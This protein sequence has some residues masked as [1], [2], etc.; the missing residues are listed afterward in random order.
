MGRL[1]A[2]SCQVPFVHQQLMASSRPLRELSR[3]AKNPP[4]KV[5][6]LVGRYEYV[7]RTTLSPSSVPCFSLFLA[8]RMSVALSHAVQL[9][10]AS[11]QRNP[12]FTPFTSGARNPSR[13]HRA[14]VVVGSTPIQRVSALAPSPLPP[15][16][17]CVLFIGV[18]G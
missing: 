8:P 7:A 9:Y 11:D 3:E 16:S 13:V 1:T 6:M 17:T 14:R 4:T 12:L 15:G 18:K 2:N 5:N 10:T